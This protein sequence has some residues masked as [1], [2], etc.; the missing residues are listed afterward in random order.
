MNPLASVPG[1]GSYPSTVT[2]ST[3]VAVSITATVSGD[4]GTEPVATPTPDKPAR[5]FSIGTSHA[6]RR[7]TAKVAARTGRGVTDL[8]PARPARLASPADVEGAEDLAEVRDPHDSSL[9]ADGLRQYLREIHNI[10]LLTSA[11]EVALAQRVEAGDASAVQAFITANLRLVVSIAKRYGGRG[12]SLID[13]I[14]EGNLGMMRAVERFDWRR[15]HKFSTY[16]TWW[17]RQAVTR[18][19]ADKSRTVRLPVHVSDEFFRLQAAQQRLTQQLGREA[20]DDDVAADLKIPLGRVRQTR[21]AASPPVS[22]DFPL[23]EDEELT[24]ADLIVDSSQPD[25]ETAV[26]QHQLEQETERALTEALTPR[27][28]LIVEMRFGLNGQGIHSLEEIGTHV[29]LTRERIRQIEHEAIGK[30]REPHVC[31]YLRHY[32][33]A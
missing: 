10:P 6:V 11:Q 29:G 7:S 3:P 4:S 12:L 1:P 23:G 17:I 20:T 33:A 15:G 31:R 30:L 8:A 14:Q 22:I 24:L 32:R 21:L 19:L 9:S 5:G 13:L 2:A 27:E 28:K 16:A 18:A 25:P 26:Q